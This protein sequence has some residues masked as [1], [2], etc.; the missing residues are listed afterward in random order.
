MANKLK[1]CK[2]CGEEIAK[3]AKTCP[4]CGAKNKKSNLLL[5]GIIALVVII[6][7]A[8]AGGSDE[9][10]KVDNPSD[11]TTNKTETPSSF[12]V[13]ETAN[14]KDVLVSLVN[15]TESNGSS[16]NT[17]QDGYVF[18]LCEF[19]IENNST[20]ELTVSSL[21][22]FEAYCDD[23]ATSM[24]ISALM[25]KGDKEQLDGKVAPGKKFNGIIGYELPTDWKE[26]EIKFTPDVWFGKDITFIAPK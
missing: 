7:A 3:N 6:I 9:P 1:K 19:T 22:S 26:L 23:Y 20:K 5:I 15:V 24:S 11:N 12:K 4:N 13:G 25:E 16:F 18:V 8:A 17:P 10:V 21:L 14:L 2:T